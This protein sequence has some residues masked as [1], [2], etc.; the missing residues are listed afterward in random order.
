[1]LNKLVNVELQLNQT[2]ESSEELHS[3]GQNEWAKLHALTCS[4]ELWERTSLNWA[5]NLNSH[6]M[7]LSSYVGNLIELITLEMDDF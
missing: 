5:D 2:S 4:I 6:V 7:A 1:M 3:H